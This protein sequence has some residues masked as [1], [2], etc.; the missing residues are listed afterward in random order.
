MKKETKD[1]EEEKEEK[2]GKK[3]NKETEAADD[4]G[5]ET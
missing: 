4:K 3:M 1:A 2:N 5:K